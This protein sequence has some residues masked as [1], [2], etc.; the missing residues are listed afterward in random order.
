MYDCIIIGMGSAGMS[1]GIYSKRLGMNTLLID[2]VM[3]GN[4]I[5]HIKN[6]ENYLGFKSISGSDLAYNMFDHIN[7]MDIQ[8]KIARVEN[9][10]IND[11]KTINVITSKGEFL[12]RG[13]II[14]SGKKFIKSGILN[15]DK[16]IGKGVSYCTICDAPLYKD[17]DV[18]FIG[19]DEDEIK[20]LN[21]ICKSVYVI[22]SSLKAVEFLGDEYL[23]GVKLSSGEIISCD[24][25]FVCLGSNA[26]YNFIRNLGITNDKGYVL[27]D[28][29]MKTN[30]DYV[31]AAGD[32]IDKSLYQ[33]ITAA[34]DGAIAATSLSRELNK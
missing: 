24:G 15:E 28:K 13:L 17:K 3:P 5:S 10:I 27:V 14:C 23:T 8:Y 29:N 25:A 18:V 11:D 21:N 12:T 19:N 6:I 9:L 33:I 34:S 20:Y 1:A 7:S 32:V 31:Y 22:D 16:Y 30:I 4:N 2:E 26:S